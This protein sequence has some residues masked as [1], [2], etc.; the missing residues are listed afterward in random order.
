MF[1][2]CVEIGF[3]G[4]P[5]WLGAPPGGGSTVLPVIPE[6]R[7]FV[8]GR[9]GQW[10]LSTV[11]RTNEEDAT[12]KA[13]YEIGGNKSQTWEKYH[14]FVELSDEP[15][16]GRQTK[17][18]PAADHQNEATQ[19]LIKKVRR[20][21]NKG[22]G[23]TRAGPSSPKL[24]DC[25]TKLSINQL[26]SRSIQEGSK[27]AINQRVGHEDKCKHIKFRLFTDEHKLREK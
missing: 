26:I 13:V 2:S 3:I 10:K 18:G 14:R 19:R 24:F 16:W 11:V 17:Q 12:F 27:Q 23:T 6:L 15:D 21:L 4:P 9:C 7:S 20:R 5:L 22:E 8:W 25:N 1:A